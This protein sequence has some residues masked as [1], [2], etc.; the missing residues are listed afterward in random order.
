MPNPFDDAAAAFAEP[1]P[2]KAMAGGENER[3]P[4][5]VDAPG[6]YDLH[7]EDYHADPC[8]DASL[9]GSIIKVMVNR[10]PRHGWNDHPRL[11]PA[12]E[13]K[14]KVTYDLGSTFHKLILGKG[15]EIEVF[16][17]KDWRTDAAKAAKAEA[18]RRGSIPLL[19]PQWENARAMERAVR[20]Q[21]PGHEELAFAMAGG[22]PERTLIW[23]EETPSGP[24]W[25]RCMLDWIPHGGALVPDWKSTEQGAGPEEWGAKTMWG[26]DADIQAAWNK[27]ALRAA[28]GQEYDLFFAVAETNAPHAIATM[29]PTPSA[30]G[31]AERKV[32]W[33]INVFGLCLYAGRW[34]GYRREMA[35]VDPPA[36]KEKSFL[37][38][39]ERDEFNI[40]VTRQLIEALGPPDPDREARVG[41]DSVDE[42]G[43]SP[44]P[45][46]GGQ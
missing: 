40:D 10:S 8:P 35:W 46:D 39:E 26:L 33:A 28:L 16:D 38:R 15:A 20:A 21:I 31:M 3:A 5:R 4:V 9:S 13:R 30:A 45:K 44:L 11:N 14:E 6:M 42:F 23:Q 36:W 17:F 29:R 32:Q 19:T 37:E 1:E 7:E 2:R 22:V 34:P 43:L 18:R 25:C 12:F 27:R 41:D 24:I